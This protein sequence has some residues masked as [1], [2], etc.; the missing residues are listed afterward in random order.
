MT[1]ENTAVVL[2]ALRHDS[3][4]LR[5]LTEDAD[6]ALD[7]LQIPIGADERAL[8]KTLA[9]K[10][11]ATASITAERTKGIALLGM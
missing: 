9:G 10:L 5:A 2:E 7:H 3:A 11:G 8:W 1:H 4:L 6:R